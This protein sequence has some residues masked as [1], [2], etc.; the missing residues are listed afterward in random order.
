MAPGHEQCQN[1]L[2]GATCAGQNTLQPHSFNSFALAPYLGCPPCE[3][4]AENLTTWTSY[5]DAPQVVLNVTAFAEATNAAKDGYQTRA[6]TSKLLKRADGCLHFV[7]C[8]FQQASQRL[9]PNTCARA[10]H[11]QV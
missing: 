3:R 6:A 7:T 4:L 1:I 11:L 10:P 9:S 5:L 2:S 8:A